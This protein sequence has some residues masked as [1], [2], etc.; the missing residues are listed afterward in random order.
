METDAHGLQ[1][2]SQASTSLGRQTTAHRHT[3]GAAKRGK[4]CSLHTKQTQLWYLV[5]SQLH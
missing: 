1:S 2:A 3:R 4:T 5:P